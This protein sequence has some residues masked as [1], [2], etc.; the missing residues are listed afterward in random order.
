MLKSFSENKTL[1]VLGLEMIVLLEAILSYF[2][3]L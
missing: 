2:R 1:V 3:V